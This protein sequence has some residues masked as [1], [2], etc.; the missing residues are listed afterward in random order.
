M[1]F[2]VIDL[3]LRIY[4]ADPASSARGHKTFFCT[5]CNT[6]PHPLN[7]F[8]EEGN[9]HHGHNK[10]QVYRTSNRP[11]VLEEEIGKLTSGSAKHPEVFH[12]PKDRGI[13]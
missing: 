7:L 10:L 6:E 3:F 4:I 1:S 12:Q 13:H 9:Q 11:S 2:Q 8:V 5:A